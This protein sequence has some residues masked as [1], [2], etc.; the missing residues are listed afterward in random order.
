M[1]IVTA[2]LYVIFSLIIFFMGLGM[3]IQNRNMMQNILENAFRPDWEMRDWREDWRPFF[4]VRIGPR[5]E[6]AA[7]D[8]SFFEEIE[9]KQVRS[10][11][12]EAMELEEESGTLVKQ[13][14][15]FQKRDT[16]NGRIIAFS[17]MSAEM[18]TMEN[19]IRTCLFIGIISFLSFLVISYLLARWAVRPVETAW[20]QQRQFVAD[21]SHELKT[22]LTV[23]MTNAELLQSPTY[24]ESQRRGMLDSILTMSHQMRGLVES[25]LELAR[26]DNGGTKMAFQ[27]LDLSELV[28]EGLLP[29]EPVYFEKDLLLESAI[30]AGIRVK[31]SASHL[32]QVLDILLDNG[33]KYTIPGSRVL[34]KLHRQGSHV[35]LSVAN[36]GEAISREDLKN[37]FKRF[38]R[39]DKARAMN[40]SYGLGL[41][42]ADSIVR[43]HKGKI[44]AESGNGLNTFFVQLPMG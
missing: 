13:K 38:Y 33:A 37:I 19:L 25:L 5:G 10:I 24:D 6:M 32:R 39:I 29:F 27:E 41:S 7:F 43:E 21:A 14:L 16:P 12:R 35:L 42:I 2:M 22:P 3:Q 28:S 11:A 23:I 36:P 44:W 30:E 4:I 9:E 31:G 8:G 26:V 20:N 15:R 17:D 40:H 34:V 1:A 18:R